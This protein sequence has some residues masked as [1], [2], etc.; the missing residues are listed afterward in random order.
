MVRPLAS[1]VIKRVTLAIGQE[2]KLP[3]CFWSP[4]NGQR[5][6]QDHITRYLRL[7]LRRQI[8]SLQQ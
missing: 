6:E 2:R 1:R 5:C 8:F 3:I 7:V 4:A